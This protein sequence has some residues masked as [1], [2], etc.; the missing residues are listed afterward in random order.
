MI[1]LMLS[2]VAP[3]ICSGCS[4]YGTVL[5]KS[6]RDD[7]EQDDFGRCIWCL[8]PTMEMHQCISCQT[9][10]GI[11]GAW[12]VG[13][14]TDALKQVLNDY[15]FE[16]RR[17]AATVLAELLDA[18]LPFLPADIVV[19]WVP[20]TS[21]HIRLR[22]F[23]HAAM[24]AGKVARMRCFD[25]AALL[26]RHTFESQHE[27][28]RTAREKAVEHAFSLKRVPTRPN[29]LLIDDVLTTGATLRACVDALKTTGAHI[30]VAVVA[31]QPAE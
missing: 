24:L 20:T 3:H 13:E 15:K 14:R 7:I 25:A 4:D 27:L 29:V 12:V 11:H 22:G 2:A 5:C 28:N 19:T 6:C 16:S 8:R 26:A 18:T 10:Y 30:Y 17:E 1:D 21:A 9:K 23:D 31:R